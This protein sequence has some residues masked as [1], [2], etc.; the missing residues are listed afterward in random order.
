MSL[1]VLIL[2]SVLFVV[3]CLIGTVFTIWF[4]TGDWLWEK[5]SKEDARNWTPPR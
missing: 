5:G 1:A 2:I 4:V 3:L